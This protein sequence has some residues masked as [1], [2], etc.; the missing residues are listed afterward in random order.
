MKINFSD[1]S[2]LAFN[3]ALLITCFAVIVIVALRLIVEFMFPMWEVGIMG[4]LIFTFSYLSIHY[5]IDKFI[6]EKIRLIYKTI[7]NLKAPRDHGK[8]VIKSSLDDVNQEVLEWTETKKKEIEE[9]KRMAD[10]R[11]EFLGNV[12]HE[13]KTPIFNIQGYILTLLDGGLEDPTINKEYLLRTEKSINRLIAIVEDLE[14]ISR[15][16]AGE[17]KLNL[18]KFDIVA[19]TREVVEFM[20]IKIKKQKITI[21]FAQS[22]DKPLYVIA[23]RDRIREVLINLIDNSIKYGNT[24]NGRTKLSFFDMDVNILIE[25]TDDGSGIEAIEL[26][27]IFERFY[28]IDKARSREQGGSGLGLAIVKHIIEAHEQTINVRSTK[29]VGTTF[30]FTLKKG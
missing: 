14:E 10:Y 1:P 13:L 30:A 11:R 7:R 25:V 16:E 28:R 12:S 9:L 8:P 15:F 27:R 17:L 5:T 26:P 3:T 24:E 21:S 20:E 22:Y 29:G 6:N 19:L 18:A 4:L 2:K 23:D